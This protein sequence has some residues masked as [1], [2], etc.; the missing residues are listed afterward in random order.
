VPTH[1]THHTQSKQ[2][3]WKG[4]RERGRENE[5]GKK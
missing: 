5:G 1:K 3:G 2:R 4:G